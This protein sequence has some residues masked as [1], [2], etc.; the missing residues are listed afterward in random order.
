MVECLIPFTSC[1]GA[2]SSLV[3]PGVVHP[4]VV[5]P[6][7]VHPGVVDL[8]VV[9]PVILVVA[10]SH[11]FP[12]A[13]GVYVYSCRFCGKKLPAGM[14]TLSMLAAGMAALAT[15][16]VPRRVSCWTVPCWFS[17]SRAKKWGGNWETCKSC[18]INSGKLLN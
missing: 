18:S 4:G 17:I 15:L 12:G 5:E 7:L 13:T 14:G 10:L 1:R 6:V 3:A 2:P 8:G 16:G 11:M 9:G